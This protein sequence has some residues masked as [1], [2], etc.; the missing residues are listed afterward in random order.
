MK[1]VPTKQIEVPGVGPCTIRQL[2]AR[3]VNRIL[4]VSTKPSASDE[5]SLALDIALV[6][7]C[8][9]EWPEGEP[10]NVQDLPHVSFKFICDQV[11]EYSGIS[12]STDAS[13]VARERGEAAENLPETPAG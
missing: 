12:K 6:K 3:E 13:E 11:L 9:T 10:E 8:T 5:E 2:T 1:Y 7:D 4:A